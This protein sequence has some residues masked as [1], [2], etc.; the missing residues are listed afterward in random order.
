MNAVSDAVRRAQD[1][2]IGSLDVL[3]NRKSGLHERDDDQQEWS[4]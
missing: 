1:K 2:N 4:D 3:I